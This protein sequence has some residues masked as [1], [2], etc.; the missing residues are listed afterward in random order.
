M[1][2][3]FGHFREFELGTES[4]LA[5]LERVQLYFV[6]ND[7]ANEKKVAVLLSVIGSKTYALLRSLLHPEAPKEKSFDQLAKTLREHL[8]PKPQTIVE[9]FHFHRRNQEQSESVL[10]YNNIAELRRL[11]ATCDFEGYL[12]E[13]LRDRF[14]CGLSN[15][16]TQ[17]RLLTEQ[18]LDLAKALEVA[19]AMEAALKNALQF[20]DLSV[21]CVKLDPK[22]SQVAEKQVTPCRNACYRCGKNNHVASNLDITS[23]I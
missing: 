18:N 6:T 7:V 8:E 23:H 21:G 10:D 4:I 2:V 17:K 3:A 12:K 16:A 15:E 9:R 5:Y 20:K 14:V 22:V 19:Q 13:V 11:S 1:A